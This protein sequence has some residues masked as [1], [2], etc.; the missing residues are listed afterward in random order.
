MRF[1]HGPMRT[2]ARLSRLLLSRALFSF[3]ASGGGGCHRAKPYT[4]YTLADGG[5]AP[6]RTSGAGPVPS[7]AALDAGAPV[8]AGPPPSFAVVP[9]TTPP[10]DGKAWPLDDAVVAV[11]PIGRSFGA[12]LVL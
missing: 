12:G 8:D 7:G 4:P 6:S 3:G 5:S 1:H 11:A 10:G 9:G 2:S